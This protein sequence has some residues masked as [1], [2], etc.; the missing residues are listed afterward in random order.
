VLFKVVKK[1][2]RKR[3]NNEPDLGCLVLPFYLERPL[4]RMTTQNS[5]MTDY[6]RPCS[7]FQQKLN[8]RK[9]PKAPVQM[10]V[11]EGLLMAQSAN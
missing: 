4:P 6:R 3:L 8:V 1:E 2:V 11:S 7:H 10:N 9:L 5:N